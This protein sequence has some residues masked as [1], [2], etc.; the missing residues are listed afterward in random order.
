MSKQKL[1]LYILSSLIAGATLISFILV[2]DL[3]F[4]YYSKTQPREVVLKVKDIPQVIPTT[5]TTSSYRNYDFGF[6]FNYSNDFYAVENYPPYIL[7]KSYTSPGKEA[8][9]V[10]LSATDGKNYDQY[11]TPRFVAVY[12]MPQDTV[13]LVMQKIITAKDQA[14]V[15]RE[16]WCK[17]NY[18]INDQI[19]QLD[20]FEQC[21]YYGG[22]WQ[23]ATTTFVGVDAIEAHFAGE[24][25]AEPVIIVPSKKIAIRGVSKLL[26]SFDF[27]DKDRQFNDPATSLHFTCP[28]FW[29]CDLVEGQ[30]YNSAL[31]GDG[32]EYILRGRFEDHAELH[33]ISTSTAE[34]NRLLEKE[35]VDYKE[36]QQIDLSQLSK[37]CLLVATQQEC[38]NY[39]FGTEVYDSPRHITINGVQATLFRKYQKNINFEETIIYAPAKGWVVSLYGQVNGGKKLSDMVLFSVVDK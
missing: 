8:Q 13:A 35:I 29:T 11:G 22:G 31:G 1:F 34:V 23:Y 17:I 3:H 9:I 33:T 2:L 24:G 28:S 5:T 39:F 4:I 30:H 19:P 37:R 36:N 16:Q 7:A 26:G 38:N 25:E 20:D 18:K 32:L 21:A 15:G 27:F 6:E 10:A 14:Q 12:T